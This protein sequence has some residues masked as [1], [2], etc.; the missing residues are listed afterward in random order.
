MLQTQLCDAGMVCRFAS[1]SALDKAAEKS[2]ANDDVIII[3]SHVMCVCCVCVCVYVCMCVCVCVCVGVE[4]GGG[5]GGEGSRKGLD[6]PFQCI[7]LWCIIMCQ[8][9][10]VML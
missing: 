4:G 9:P 5:G 8:G 10:W 2:R 3:V 1:I 6:A 7:L